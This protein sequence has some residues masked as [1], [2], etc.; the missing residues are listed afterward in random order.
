MKNTIQILALLAML[1][2]S[3]GGSRAA[4]KTGPVQGGLSQYVQQARTVAYENN[5]SEG[6]LWTSN[7]RSELFRDL[8]AYRIADIVT[9]AVSESTSAISTATTETSKTSEFESSASPFFGLEKRISELSGLIESDRTSD[10]EGD[11]STTRSSTLSTT[12]TARV[13]EVFP[14]GN[15]LL[16][17][18]R[19]VLIN[20][21][22]QIVTI[23][24]VTRPADISP[25]NIVPSNALAELEVRV[26]GRGIVADAQKR[27]ILQAI[28]S[29]LWPF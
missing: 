21:E 2:I 19:E 11:A 6:S 13:V 5:E 1:A 20:G 10:F 25:G 14:N 12:V 28:L 22:R 27:G 7:G 8:K 29:G 4:K 23:R 18:N 16:E 24:G 17:G 3:C 9:I 15:L 26:N